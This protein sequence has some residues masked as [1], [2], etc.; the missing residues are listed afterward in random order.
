MITKEMQLFGLLSNTLLLMGV[1]DSYYDSKSDSYKFTINT[2]EFSVVIREKDVVIT[3]MHIQS[4]KF[5]RVET[6]TLV[7]FSTSVA[8]I[9]EQ[10][11][12]WFFLYT[13]S[14][15]SNN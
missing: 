11:N 1:Q 3:G 8:I 14:P 6:P 13:L 10:F 15:Y 9:L 2:L 7:N 5:I 12:R 4:N